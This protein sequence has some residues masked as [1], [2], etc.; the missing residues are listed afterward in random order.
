[1][2]YNTPKP[3]Y[4][5]YIFVMNVED[6]QWGGHAKE[7]RRQLRPLMKHHARGRLRAVRTSAIPSARPLER[8]PEVPVAAENADGVTGSHGLTIPEYQS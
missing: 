6:S 7:V 8:A 4:Y 5:I 3:L 1:M 2:L